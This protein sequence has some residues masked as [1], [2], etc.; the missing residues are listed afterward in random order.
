LSDTLT[1]TYIFS[2]DLNGF[3][4]T[5]KGAFLSGKKN[6]VGIH[7]DTITWVTLNNIGL[8]EKIYI[9]PQKKWEIKANPGS[10]VAATYYIVW[11]E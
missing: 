8:N 4:S 5:H 10:C 1:H 9:V 6:M 2:Y 7:S 3:I 11:E